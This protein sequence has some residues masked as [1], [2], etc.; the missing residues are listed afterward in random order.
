MM[1]YDNNQ[2]TI[3]YNFKSINFRNMMI[4]LNTNM[5]YL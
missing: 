4:Q 2:I 5:L 1:Q 3:K